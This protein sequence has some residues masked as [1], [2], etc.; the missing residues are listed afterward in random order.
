MS[1]GGRRNE[2]EWDLFVSYK[3]DA[4][5]HRLMTPWVERLLEY[6]R[7]WLSQARGGLP[8]RVFFDKESI[9]IGSDWPEELRYAILRSRCL[10][11]I[12]TPEYFQSRWCLAEWSSFIAR[13]RL[14]PRQ[15]TS[16]IMPVKFCDG[17]WFPRE[18][19]A[20]Q[21][22]D[23]SDYASL[24]PAVWNSPDAKPLELEQKIR[25]F[26]EQLAQ[27]IEDAPGFRDWPI[28]SPVP[29][30]PTRNVAM[31]RL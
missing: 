26:A 25:L 4:D 17:T 20:I 11:P 31:R 23:L 1:M 28:K 8:A 9:E 22:L 6:L 15:Q 18:A 2:Y 5:G 13:R 16:V 3:H 12:L 19:K 14:L 29:K 24:M 30:P 21:H 27:V 10:L 7:F